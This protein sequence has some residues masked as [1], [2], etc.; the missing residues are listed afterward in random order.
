MASMPLSKNSI[1]ICVLPGGEV[2]D[3][4]VGGRALVV[5]LVD[6]ELVVEVQPDAVVGGDGEPVPA[7]GE[8]LRS[9]TSGRRSRRRRTPGRAARSTR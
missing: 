9:W 1:R 2:G 4:V 5:P 8:E 7:G 3:V 6:D